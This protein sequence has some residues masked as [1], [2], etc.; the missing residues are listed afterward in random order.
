MRSSRL[1][2]RSAALS[3]FRIIYPGGERSTKDHSEEWSFVFL[4]FCY[5]RGIRFAARSESIDP[6][7][8]R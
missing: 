1:K 3:V 6:L 8:V 7:P 4:R 2:R 5:D